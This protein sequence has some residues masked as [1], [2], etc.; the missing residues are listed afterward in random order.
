MPSRLRPIHVAFLI[1]LFAELLFLWGLETPHI[2]VFDEIHY[3]P[4]A[5]ALL[6]LRGPVNTEHPLVAKELIAAGMMLFGDNPFGWRFFSTI[7]G[8]AT[9]MG[10]FAITFLLFQRVRPAVMASAYTLL[11]FMLY[12]QARIA[13]IDGYLAAFTI[14]AIAALLWA[15]RAPPDK[16]WRRLI[17]SGVLFGLAVAT[18]WAAV[19]YLAGAGIGLLIVRWRDAVAAKKPLAAALSG[20]DQPHWAGLPAIPAMLVLG[21]VAVLTYFLTFAPAFF[22]HTNPMTLG[23]LLPFQGHM[24]AEQTQVL[25]HHRYQSPWWSWPLLIR[26]IWYLYEF[27]DGAQRGI[28][29]L[30]NPAIMWSGLVAIAACLWAG[31]KGDRKLLVV[32]CMYL[33]SWLIWAIIPKSL[34]FFYYYYLPSLFLCIA[35]AA[36][37]DRYARGKFEHWDEAFAI[38]AFGLFV[39]FFP[40]LSAAEL[41][42][43]M[44]YQH[45]MW[46]STWP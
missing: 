17:V 21:S 39:Y 32:A 10:V 13:M 43:E 34:G 6:D 7:A 3:V 9:L 30:G 40:I 18:K 29:L 35:L 44:A 37:F 24:W 45:W 36:A 41:S 22:Y 42:G 11:G 5:R 25:P 38:F 15:M 27:A 1:G 2:L 46:F 16:A 23:E 12:V 8:S 20:M 26:P 28:I 19:P 33:G 31:I 14:L 4:A